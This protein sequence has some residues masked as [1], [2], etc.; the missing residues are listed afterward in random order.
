[1]RRVDALMWFGLLGAPAAWAAQH[2]TGIALTIA[3]CHDNAAGPRWQ[4]H[5]DAW[6][7]VSTSIAAVVAILAGLSAVAAW[8]SARDADDSDPPPAGRV[9]FLGIVGLTI[10]P[11]FLAI[12]LMSG[13]GSIS[14]AQCVQS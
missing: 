13:F 5:V 6:T 14:L 2:V 11:L 1:V 4:A 7:V 8:R 9:H 3:E 12:I 10:S